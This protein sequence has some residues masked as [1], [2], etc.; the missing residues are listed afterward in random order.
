MRSLAQICYAAFA[1]SKAASG[2]DLPLWDDLTA[3]DK[4]AW[5]AA[6]AAVCDESY[7]GIPKE[8]INR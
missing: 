8:M 3:E 6:A 2:E 4:E 5:T 1:T 7:D